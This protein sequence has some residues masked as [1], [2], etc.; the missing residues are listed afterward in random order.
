MIERLLEVLI[1]LSWLW[2]ADMAASASAITRC[3][4]SAEMNLLAYRGSNPRLC[5]EAN[6]FIVKKVCVRA[7]V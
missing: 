1:S 3:I 5:S 6:Q 4:H 2:I 7:I